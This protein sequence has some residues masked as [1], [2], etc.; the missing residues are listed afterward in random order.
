MKFS[1]EKQLGRYS[2]QKKR[3]VDIPESSLQAHLDGLVT[4]LRISTIR[5]P[6]SFFKWIQVNVSLKVRKW[7]NALFAALPDSTLFIPI[8]KE[9]NLACKIECKTKTNLHGRQV[10]AAKDESW[11]IVR[12]PL[13][14][15]EIVVKFR[16]QAEKCKECLQNNGD[17]GKL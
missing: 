14:A 6:D 3:K 2:R 7:F 15:D 8:S 5:I 12:T 10:Q 16:D 17:C 4:L 1:K 13:E 11:V 9:F